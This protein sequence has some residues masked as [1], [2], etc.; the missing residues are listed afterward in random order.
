MKVSSSFLLF[1][2]DDAMKI[3][4]ASNQGIGVLEKKTGIYEILRPT[5]SRP[6]SVAS[7]FER[8]MYFWVDEVLNVFVL[9]KPNSIPLYPGIFLGIK[10]FHLKFK[11]SGTDILFI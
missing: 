11:H 4:I 8:E 5:K 1:I 2:A 10:C 9:G 7:D 6:T 3:L